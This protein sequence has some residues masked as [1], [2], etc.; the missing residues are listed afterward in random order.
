M[1]MS[2]RA[3]EGNEGT[4]AKKSFEMKLAL[5]ADIAEA[6]VRCDVVGAG[7]F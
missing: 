7:T 4:K 1:A 3:T 6:L 5:P 2:T